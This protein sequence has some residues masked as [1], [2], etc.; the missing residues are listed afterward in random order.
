MTIYKNNFVFIYEGVK[1]EGYLQPLT[2]AKADVVITTYDV[3][4][5]ELYFA[6]A[7]FNVGEKRSRRTLTYMN[8]PSP[9]LS[10]EFWRLCLDEAQMVEGS[11]TRAAEMARK[12]EAIHRWC[13][14][15]TPI[16]KVIFNS[17]TKIEL[18]LYV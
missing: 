12:L 2:I 5:T 1:N 3:L 7:K 11:T 16:Q 17:D 14:T 10:I 15:G 8:A 9:L 18:K 13:V 6:D 4:R